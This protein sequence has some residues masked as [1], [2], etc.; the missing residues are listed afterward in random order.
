MIHFS[1]CASDTELPPDLVLR[2]WAPE[3]WL[4]IINEQRF[5]GSSSDFQTIKLEASSRGVGASGE[6]PLIFSKV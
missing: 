6:I 1:D 3:T 4:M 5:P 2:F